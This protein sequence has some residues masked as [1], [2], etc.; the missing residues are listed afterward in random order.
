MN[1]V[2]FPTPY[3]F[4]IYFNIILQSPTWSLPFKF[5]EQYVLTLIL[6][7]MRATSPSHHTVLHFYSLKVKITLYKPNHY[8]RGSIG[9]SLL[10]NTC[11]RG[12]NAAVFC[13][14]LADHS[15]YLKYSLSWW[16]PVQAKQLPC[17]KCIGSFGN[18]VTQQTWE[19]NTWINTVTGPFQHSIDPCRILCQRIQGNSFKTLS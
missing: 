10:M 16:F 19:M 14:P 6:A 3:S 4:K 12:T 1:P 2:H 7:T 18:V 9:Y 13:Q 17:L 11:S 15:V 5:P 8:G